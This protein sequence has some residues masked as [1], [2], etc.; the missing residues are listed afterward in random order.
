MCQSCEDDFLLNSYGTCDTITLTNGCSSIHEYKYQNGS[1][2]LSCPS[3]FKASLQTGGRYCD[4]PCSLGYFLYQDNTCSPTCNPDFTIRLQDGILFCDQ[5]PADLCTVVYQSNIMTTTCKNENNTCS[6]GYFQYQNGSCLPY[7]EVPYLGAIQQGSALCLSPCGYD[8]RLYPDGTCSATCRAG[9]VEKDQNGARFCVALAPNKTTSIIIQT[10]TRYNISLADFNS[11]DGADKFIQQSASLLE[12][13]PSLIT[14]VDLREGS[15]IVESQ[16]I[17]PSFSD[18]ASVDATQSK[19]QALSEKLSYAVNHNNLD[20][21][22]GVNVLDYESNIQVSLPS[23]CTPGFYLNEVT[24]A[25]DACDPSCSTCFGAGP[26][27]CSSCSILKSLADDN[28]CQCPAGSVSTG[29]KAC[30][31]CDAGFYPNNAAGTCD[32]CDPSCPTCFG[33]GPNSCLSCSAQKI[34]SDDNS[35]KCPTGS[36]STGPQTC[37]TCNAGYYADD[38][39]G[40]C[41]KCDASCATCSGAGPNACSS[42]SSQKV[43]SSS[44]SC[45]CPAGSYSTGP[46]TCIKCDSS[47]FFNQQSLKCQSCDSSCATCSGAGSKACLSCRSPKVLADDSSCKC[48]AG[49]VSLGN[50]ICLPCSPG[51]Y[52]NDAL[53]L[54]LK[55]DLSCATCSG[56]GPNSCSSCAGQK[57]LSDSNSCECSAGYYSTGFLTCAK[58][59][60]SCKT[61]SGYGKKACTSC[62]SPLILSQNGMCKSQSGNSGNSRTQADGGNED[63]NNRRFRF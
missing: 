54:C 31:V 37:I 29:P 5:P 46:T 8:K 15:T 33:Y 3:P 14:I 23:P 49:S 16:I 45:D 63:S 4:S 59:D 39:S 1:C 21:I 9:F 17:L 27:S 13:D 44:S 28:S 22:D 11:Q 41:Q 6:A 24:G 62:A 42:C 40:T 26:N 36:V 48:P 43:L 55:C 53:G 18:Q 25:C 50:L 2:L 34:L 58:C 47:S 57:T 60:S 30:K 52:A 56:A 19:A 20:V 51:F 32:A 38:T 61:C 10:S 7:C 12:I 35:C